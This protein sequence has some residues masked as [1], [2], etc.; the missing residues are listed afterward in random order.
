MEF[1]DF[2]GS[3]QAPGEARFVYL[4][5]LL[6]LA[7]ALARCMNEA[8]METRINT[9]MRELGEALSNLTFD[10]QSLPNWVAGEFGE[11]ELFWFATA[12]T[13]FYDEGI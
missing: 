3:P 9:K 8:D 1:W 12:M 13:A 4:E 2:I 11:D 6:G 5:I 10:R 7:R